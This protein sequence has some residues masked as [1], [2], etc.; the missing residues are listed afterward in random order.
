MLLREFLISEHELLQL[1]FPSLNVQN[2][3]PALLDRNEMKSFH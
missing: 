2:M 3:E 1:E